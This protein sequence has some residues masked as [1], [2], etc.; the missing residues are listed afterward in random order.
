M[1]L[2]TQTLGHERRHLDMQDEQIDTRTC[3]R[4]QAR[5]LYS[6]DIYNVVKTFTML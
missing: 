6:K 4:A 1:Q 3:K 5:V 2:G